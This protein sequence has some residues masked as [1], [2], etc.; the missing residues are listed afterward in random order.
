[1]DKKI[2]EKL[3]KGDVLKYKE[4]NHFYTTYLIIDKVENGIASGQMAA[5]VGVNSISLEELAKKEELSIAEF[6]LFKSQ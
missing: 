4:K 5:P 6:K 1:M 3:R 2:L